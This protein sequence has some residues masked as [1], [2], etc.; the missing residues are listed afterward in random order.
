[1]PGIPKFLLRS[2]LGLAFS[3]AIL[4]VP[5]GSL[6]FWQGWVFLAVLLIPGVYSFL[7]FRKHD[8]QLIA[9]RLQ[10]KEK[11]GEQKRLVALWKPLILVAFFLPGLDYRFGW[12]RIYL[13]ATSL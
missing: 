10:T 3:A 13:G 7:Y 5:A 8:P 6:R 4:F 12:S 2:C 1:M 11:I 9:R